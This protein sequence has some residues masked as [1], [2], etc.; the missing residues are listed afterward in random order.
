[1]LID[2]AKP[3]LYGILALFVTECNS[4]EHVEPVANLPFPL[5]MQTSTADSSKIVLMRT[6]RTIVDL[7]EGIS[8]RWSPDGSQIAFWANTSSGLNEIFAMN[9]DGSNIRNLTNSPS[10]Y[11]TRPVWAP[12]GSLIAFD[13][14]V[15]GGNRGIGIMKSDGVDRHFVST[16][17]SYNN[18]AWFPNGG[19]LLFQKAAGLR[20]EIHRVNADGTG[21]TSMTFD[22]TKTFANGKIS[23]NGVYFS[24]SRGAISALTY[25]SMVIRDLTNGKEDEFP[26]AITGSF[27][28]PQSDWLYC[29]ETLVNGHTIVRISPTSKV[30]QDLSRKPAA[31]AYDDVV[32]SLSS[33][34]RWLAFMSDRSGSDLIYMMSAEGNNQ[35]P[36]THDPQFSWGMWKP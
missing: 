16:N 19:S 36:I 5:M 1:M 10:R 30:K 15:L 24:Y 26:G 18:V 23:P 17:S 4:V 6:D 12:D 27:W 11:E 7:A 14:E 34:G 25:T 31:V 21:D 3:M 22:T 28:S 13:D 9:S 33:D 32:S 29:T 35:Q 20:L 8:P 2:S